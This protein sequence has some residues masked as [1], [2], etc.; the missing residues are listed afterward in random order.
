MAALFQTA[1]L[2]APGQQVL[3]LRHFSGAQLE[4]LLREEAERWQARHRWEYTRSVD[5]LLEYLDS[6]VLPGF[7]AVEGSARAR[8]VLGYTFCVYEGEKA[9]VGDVYAFGE[10]EDRTSPVSALLLEHLLETLQATPGVRRIESQLLL[11]DAGSLNRTFDHFDFRPFPRLFMLAEL[12]SPALLAAP[13]ASAEVKVTRWQPE[14]YN[15]AAVL[16]HRCYQDHGDA[17]INDQY[18]TISGAQRFLHNI[19]RFPGC[20]QFDAEGSL[21]LRDVHSGA[22]EGI[23]LCSRVR[24]DVA[25]ITQLCVNPALRGRGLGH[26]LLHQAAH[27]LR[28]RGFRS[29]SLTVTEANH[30]ALALYE[31][32][33]FTAQ[34]RFE[35]MTWDKP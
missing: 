13:R 32:L 16:I 29:V 4:P 12:D 25:H 35:A 9:V 2:H 7:A 21:M 28:R 20:G 18:Q 8:R 34:H 10:G 24:G 11:F 15:E 17:L 6:R 23:L 30:K 14:Q 27:E 3:D 5:L 19:I 33:G 22:L 1:P 31:S 26:L